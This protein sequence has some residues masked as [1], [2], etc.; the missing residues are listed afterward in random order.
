MIYI[1][2][3]CFIALL[4]IVLVEVE[5]AD[6]FKSIVKKLQRIFDLLA[7]ELKNV[8]IINKI[9]LNNMKALLAI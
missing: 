2:Y 1:M 8:F 6:D 4:N 9:D 7:M 5:N 3:V